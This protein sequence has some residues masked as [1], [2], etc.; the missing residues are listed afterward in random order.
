MCFAM[1]LGNLGAGHPSKGW[2]F[3]RKNCHFSTFAKSKTPRKYWL[4][5]RKF[6]KFLEKRKYNLFQEGSEHC[7]LKNIEN[8]NVFVVDYVNTWKISISSICFQ[9]LSFLQTL[10]K[11][12]IF[13]RDPV[14]RPL[15]NISAIHPSQYL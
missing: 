1:N 9:I 12:L 5:S 8:F 14:N 13:L 10:G 11:F 15:Q 6:G 3:W 2:A 4:F 7:D